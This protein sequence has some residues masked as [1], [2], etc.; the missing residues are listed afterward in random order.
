MKIALI[1]ERMDIELGGAERS[2]SE[3]SQALTDQGLEVTLLA[4]KG[5]ADNLR[6][7][8]LC[9]GSGKRT[10]HAA[11]AAALKAHMHTHSYDIVHSVLPFDFAD[12]YQPRGGSYAETILRNAASYENP[13]VSGW[14]RVTA[15]TNQRRQQWL[16]AERVVSQ[17]TQGPV[18]AA[19]SRYVVSQFKQHYGTPE[20]RIALIANGVHTHRP[21]DIEAVAQFKLAVL[22]QLKCQSPVLFL[23]GAHNF[24]LKGL[25]P[26]LEAMAM[27]KHANMAL[28]IAG[29]GPQAPYQNLINKYGLENQVLFLGATSHMPQALAACDVAV[30]PTFYDP[31]SRFI[32]EA[33]AAQKPVITTRFNGAC[34]LFEANRHGKIIDSPTQI[35][36]LAEALT[37]LLDDETR[38]TMTRAIADDQLPEKVSIERVAQ[39]L[40]A[41]YTDILSE[42]G[43]QCS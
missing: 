8:V 5:R 34:D 25:R 42:K 36:A 27:T 9:E 37:A 10:S 2:V 11:F 12:V 41:L 22:N 38:H 28:L 29:N 35:D 7:F 14:K 23:F 21:V 30:L 18:I 19:L 32:L 40:I 39:E 16:R 43:K 4:A 13:L 3:L 6:S 31:A 33:L 20:E 15:F 17:G 26:L 1:I 24:R